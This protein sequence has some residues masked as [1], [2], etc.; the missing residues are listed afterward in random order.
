MVVARQ[1][2]GCEGVSPVESCAYFSCNSQPPYSSAHF[3]YIGKSLC[4]VKLKT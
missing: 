3:M 4:L 1:G 2:R